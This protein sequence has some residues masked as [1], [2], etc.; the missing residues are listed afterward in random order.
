[1]LDLSKHKTPFNGLSQSAGQNVPMKRSMIRT[2]WKSEVVAMVPSIFE[3][4][5]HGQLHHKD[6]NTQ[7]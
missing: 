1:M 5:D 6:E 2:A 4:S 7:T 3:D